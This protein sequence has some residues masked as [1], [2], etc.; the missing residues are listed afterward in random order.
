MLS[1][2]CRRRWPA[3][4][5]TWQQ[6]ERCAPAQEA[7][8]A[9]AALVACSQAPKQ[10]AQ[11]CEDLRLSGCARSAHPPLR[12]GWGRCCSHAATGSARCRAQGRGDGRAAHHAGQHSEQR[13]DARRAVVRRGQRAGGVPGAVGRRAAHAGCDAG[14]WRAALQAPCANPGLLFCW[15]STRLSM[16]GCTH[17]EL[18]PAAL[19]RGCQAPTRQTAA[20]P[21]R[22]RGRPRAARTR[23]LTAVAALARTPRPPARSGP[24]RATPMALQSRS[25]AAAASAA[26][27]AAAAAGCSAGRPTTATRCTA[28]HARPLLDWR[29]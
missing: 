6:S 23:R 27:A 7:E 18:T 8:R 15:H 25:W 17:A 22:G 28:R 1:W 12:P 24:R 2:A 9:K 29:P 13:G 20:P 4:V 10:F 3:T 11:R 5:P 19:P 26:T 21:R 14:P 16:R